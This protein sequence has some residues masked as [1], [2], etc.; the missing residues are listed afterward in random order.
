MTGSTSFFQREAN[1]DRS[2]SGDIVNSEISWQTFAFSR[3]I[4]PK[5]K[6]VRTPRGRQA[7]TLELKRD[8]DARQVARRHAVASLRSI[9]DVNAVDTKSDDASRRGD[10]I[11]VVR[12]GVTIPMM[13]QVKRTA[14]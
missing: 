5:E 6:K 7:V 1:P 9:A 2:G 4:G 12:Y 3:S 11:N 14:I 10:S 8:R 13:T